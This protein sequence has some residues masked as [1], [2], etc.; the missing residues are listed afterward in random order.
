MLFQGLD[1]AVVSTMTP[2]VVNVQQILS[3]VINNWHLNTEKGLSMITSPCVKVLATP[4]QWEQR[5]RQPSQHNG[6]SVHP[7]PTSR[8]LS[9]STQKKPTAQREASTYCSPHC[10]FLLPLLE[11]KWHRQRKP[12]MCM[13]LKLQIVATSWETWLI[14]H[15]NSYFSRLVRAFHSLLKRMLHCQKSE[16]EM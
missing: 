3:A 6:H 10:P 1:V 4:G 14:C 16:Q 11:G 8:T 5:S 7:A 12:C 2:W 15:A 9:A 13:Q